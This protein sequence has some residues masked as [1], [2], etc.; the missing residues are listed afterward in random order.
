MQSIAC[1]ARQRAVAGSETDPPRMGLMAVMRLASRFLMGAAIA[2]ASFCLA[3]ATPASCAP[4]YEGVWWNSPPNSESGWGINLTHQ[5]DAIFVSWFTYDVSGQGWWL[6]MTANKTAEGIYSGTL[7]ETAGP[8]FSADPFDPAKVTRTQV[9]SGTLTFRDL[10]SGTFS[11]TL[12]G[13]SQT[14]FIARLVFGPV[15]TCTY[16][17]RPD[18]GAAT[19][20]QDLWWVANGAESGWGLNVA[21]QGDVIFASWFTYDSDGAP[22]WLSATAAKAAPNIYRGELIRTTGPAF[23]A[24]PFDATIVT[25]TVVGMATFTFA[26]GNAATF[27][28]T[29]DGVSQTKTITR[30]LFVPPAGTVCGGPDRTPAPVTIVAAGDIAQCG[31]APSASGAAKTAALIDDR[32]GLVLTLGDNAYDKGRAAEFA[33]CF[34]PTWG[35]FKDRIRPSPGNHEYE[36]SGA[37]GYFDYFGAQAGPDR[38]G[39]YSFDYGGWHFISLNSQVDVSP[40]SKQ[41]LWLTADLAQSRDSLCTIAYWHYPAFSSGTEHGSIEAMRPFFDA[42]YRAGVEIVLSGHEHNYE[43]FGPQN[44]NGTADPARGVREFVVGTGGAGLYPLGHPIANSEYRNNTTWGVLRLTLDQG[45]YS[46]QFMPAGGGD[47][48]DS[49]TGICHP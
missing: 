7:I 27:A 33:S 31:N 44:A 29:M 16:G 2:A 20:Y 42:L 34:Q 40:E 36:T 48:I 19:N 4:N 41:Y 21:H 25:R 15:P 47:A 37:G 8:A 17:A 6:S 38:R 9:G 3:F 13:V 49:G 14:K 26:N 22:L 12:D 45:S 5:G 30:Q 11:F 1:H 43:R 32:D 39:Y 28:Y 35:A 10:D 23:N 24:A 18:F 46:W